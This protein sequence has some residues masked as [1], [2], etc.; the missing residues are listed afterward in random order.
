MEWFRWSN[1]F[2]VRTVDGPSAIQDLELIAVGAV[3]LDDIVGSQQ[4]S[5]LKV[6]L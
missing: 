3:R 2:D 4:V 1:W 6:G 5:L